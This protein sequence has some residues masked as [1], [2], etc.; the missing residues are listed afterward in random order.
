MK[1]LM[2]DRSQ[3]ID[4]RIILEAKSLLAKGYEVNL[5]ATGTDENEQRESHHGLNVFRIFSET[6]YTHRKK[7]GPNCQVHTDPTLKNDKIH[8]KSIARL[9][10]IFRSPKVARLI[11]GFLHPRIFLEK[12]DPLQI[13]PLQ[14]KILI[15]FY[16][17]L[18][19]SPKTLM[20]TLRGEIKKESFYAQE[21]MN[22]V[23]H[24][25]NKNKSLPFPK[26]DYWEKTV[27]MTAINSLFRPDIIHAH[28]YPALKAAVNLGEL[29]SVPVIYDAHELFSYQPGMPKSISRIIFEE[30]KALVVHIHRVVVVN[31]EQ[32]KIMQKDFKLK[33]FTPLTNATEEPLY[34][35][36]NKKYDLFRQTLN[37]T[38]DTR[39]LMFQGGINRLRKIDLLLEG[40]AQTPPHIHLV[41]LTFGHEVVEFKEMA[42][43]LGIGKRVHF[44]GLVPWD[45]VVYWAASADAGIMPY[46]PTDWNTTISSPNKMYEFITAGTPMIGHSGL[47]NVHKIVSGEGFGVLQELNTPEN[48]AQAINE[49]FD[50]TKGGAARFKP[51]LHKNRLKYEWQ[52]E[53]QGFLKL[54]DEIEKELKIKPAILEE[55]DAAVIQPLIL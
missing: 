52:Y 29:L 17:A 40:I 48:F 19:L 35:D 41:F 18:T 8:D 32:G 25:E 44:L 42:N 11:F 55:K 12:L 36:I 31:E 38:Q 15:L 27:I 7:C 46:H 10:K 30:E 43:K 39:I 20:R 51:N 3:M 54:Y 16:G 2:I 34:F 5:I 23:K 22:R 26:M 45:Q 6:T 47:V 24:L 49:M 21:I 4:R 53:C 1:I 37:L 13:S 14:K 50:E 9:K 28:D 33:G